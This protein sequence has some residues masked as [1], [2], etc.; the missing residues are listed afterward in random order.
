MNRRSLLALLALPPLLAACGEGGGYSAGFGDSVR[1]PALRAPWEFGD[2]SHWNGQPAAA[3]RAVSV[4]EQLA[5]ALATDPFWTPEVSPTVVI[6]LQQAR[7]EVRQALGID[8][9]ATPDNVRAALE[10]AAYALDRYD[11]EAAAVALTGPAFHQPGA[12]TLHRLETLPRLPR[13]SEAA[14]GVAAEMGRLDRR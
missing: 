1:R 10:T 9:R 6:Q 3:A 2:L 13:A 14:S 11:R 8:P 4:L 5:D 7:A 12:E